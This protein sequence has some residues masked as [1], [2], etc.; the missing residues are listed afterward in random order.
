MSQRI[1]LRH[2]LD[3]SVQMEAELRRDGLRPNVGRQKKH[4]YNAKRRSERQFLYFR[5][6]P[7]ARSAALRIKHF[8]HLVQF[9]SN[10][11][12]RERLIQLWNNPSY[13]ALSDIDVSLVNASAGIHVITEIR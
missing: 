8:R 6:V 2:E 12:A 4:R 13:L 11:A 3:R 7:L 1:F 10:K 5:F 9:S